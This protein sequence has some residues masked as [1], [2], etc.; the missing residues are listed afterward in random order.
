MRREEF[1]GRIVSKTGKKAVAAAV[2]ASMALS[3]VTY[4]MTGNAKVAEEK[5]TATIQAFVS[6]DVDG[7]GTVELKDAQL[8]LKAALDLTTLTE[9][10]EYAADVD[11]NNKVELKDAQMILRQALDLQNLPEK[12]APSDEPQPSTGSAV[13]ESPAPSEAPKES[14]I[15]PSPPVTVVPKS[16]EPKPTLP[17]V[18]A[19]AENVVAGQDVKVRALNGAQKM[20]VTGASAETI[21]FG[22]IPTPATGQTVNDIEILGVEM[23]NPFAGRTDLQQEVTDAVRTTRINGRQTVW[24]LTGAALVDDTEGGGFDFKTSDVRVRNADSVYLSDPQNIDYTR[25]EWAH[26]VSF[27]FWMKS[28]TKG[29]NAPA[30]VFNDGSTILSLRMNGT[31][32]F[33]DSLSTGRKANIFYGENAAINGTYGDWN[34][35][36]ITIKNDWIQTYVNGQE[37]VYDSVEL[38]RDE[39]PNFNDGFLS[40]YTPVTY[41]TEA[42]INDYKVNNPRL[43]YYY[44]TRCQAAKPAWN[45]GLED[46]PDTEGDER[47]F[48]GYS[49][50]TNGRFGGG[51]TGSTLLLD[52][53]TDSKC[54]MWIGGTRTSV[55]SENTA[56]KVSL[57]TNIAEVK[58]YE[59]ELTPE[60]VAANYAFTTVTPTAITWDP[61]KAEEPGSSEDPGSDDDFTVVAQSQWAKYNEETGIVSFNEVSDRDA[62]KARGGSVGLQIQNPFVNKKELVQ[63]LEEALEGQEIFPYRKENG[64]T[65]EGEEHMLA[66]DDYAA[67][68]KYGNFYDVYYGPTNLRGDRMNP[69]TCI[70]TAGEGGIILDSSITGVKSIEWLEQNYGNQ[71]TTFQRPKWTKGASISFWAKPVEV[72]DSPLIT[73]SN[74]NTAG[75]G[76]ILSV[77]VRGDV[78]FF[79]LDKR[80]DN[81]Y[82]WQSSSISNNGKPLN[83]F[84][85]FGDPEYVKAGEWNYYTITIANDWITVYVNGKEMVYTQVNLNRGQ[86]KKFNH[87]YLTRYNTIGIWTK[88]MVEAYERET[89]DKD[90]SGHTLDGTQREYLIKS[91]HIWDLNAPD[92]T[93]KNGTV[94]TAIDDKNATNTGQD[95]TSI[96][97]N[98]V[99]ADPLKKGAGTIDTY[100]L[101]QRLTHS[102]TELYLGGIYSQINLAG[103]FYIS[104]L[105]MS[106]DT[107]RTKVHYAEV[108]EGQSTGHKYWYSNHTLDAGTE[109]TSFSSEMKE[110]TAEEVKT[111]YESAV[112][113]TE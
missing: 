68:V 34:Y 52:F 97:F 22:P 91:H 102:D 45:L 30:L 48:D 85:A 20:I 53:I 55:E 51:H 90:L 72:D 5:K 12:P 70:G 19:K 49:V 79:S 31:V 14:K 41:L 25:P 6:G 1:W 66:C 94:H 111:A 99:Y 88:D 27:S 82:D 32:R 80:E 26:G 59:V 75:Y 112:K 63:T 3:G 46:D 15:P 39:M 113:P 43:Y 40:R 95:A 98:G 109:I 37:V 84:A 10:Q 93:D 86:M 33:V 92:S 36:T 61:N 74:N 71:K 28:D 2:A 89:G 29:N 104:D 18:E 100:D 76:T 16:A 78:F 24:E 87:G 77:S 106:K 62:N 50:F 101:M 47:F 23:E 8:C 9:L 44:I 69:A 11:S 107:D 60:Q 105:Q 67:I 35:Y 96:R 42:Q 56:R 65:L 7:N 81:K 13:T 57:N 4:A 108:A 58:A 21:V 83:T 110:M 64:G 38:S 103:E 17:A 73:F 54:K